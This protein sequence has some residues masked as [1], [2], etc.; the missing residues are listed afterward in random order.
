M[1]PVKMNSLARFSPMSRGSTC[2]PPQP[3]MTPTR[4]SGWPNLAVSAAIARSVASTSSQPP[5]RAR[6]LT[7]AMTGLGSSRMVSCGRRRALLTTAALR[8]RVGNSSMSAPALKAWSP[9]P[10]MTTTYTSSSRP[11]RSRACDISARSS[12]FCAFRFSGRFS[13]IHAV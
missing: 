1:R 5:P 11:A 10:V 8:L 6:P 12:S 3:G 2:V 13:V 4:I 9:L 7:E